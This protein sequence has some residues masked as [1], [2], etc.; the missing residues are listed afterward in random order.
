MHTYVHTRNSGVHMN[1]ALVG[2]G[3]VVLIHGCPGMDTVTVTPLAHQ[4]HCVPTLDSPQVHG[5]VTTYIA[6]IA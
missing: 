5:T 4:W 2:E 6:L 3:S 1:T